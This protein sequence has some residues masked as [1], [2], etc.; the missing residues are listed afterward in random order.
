MNQPVRIFIADDHPFFTE[1]VINAIKPYPQ[2]TI[3]GT[4]TNSKEVINFLLETQ[5]D[6]TILDLNMP[7]QNG[8]ELI[9]IIK[10]KYPTIKILVL[11]MYMPA[12]IKLQPKKAGIDA[13][14]LKN[15]GTEILL[16]AIEALTQ[17]KKYFDINIEVKNNHSE[18]GFSKVLKLS[19]REK[20]ILAMIKTGNNTNAIATALFISELTVKTHRKNIMAKMGAKNVADLVNKS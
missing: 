10:V 17:N 12:D 9:E 18:D 3:I 7:G 14:V 15:S 5:P 4:A 19:T 6:I 13:Y 20:E 8:L 11:S 2:Y 1:G 16:T